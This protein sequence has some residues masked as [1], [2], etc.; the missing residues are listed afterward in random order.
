ML[1]FDPTRQQPPIMP[2]PPAPGG[3]M[4]AAV[5]AGM[6][7]M[8]PPSPEPFGLAVPTDPMAAQDVA[9]PVPD[10]MGTGGDPFLDA[11]MDGFTKRTGFK[12][13]RNWRE[14]PKPTAAQILDFADDQEKRYQKLVDR[15]EDDRKT[16]MLKQSGNFKS[17]DPDEDEEIAGT[18]MTDEINLVANIIAGIDLQLENVVTDPA[19]IEAAQRN[20][21]FLYRA[22]EEAID[23]HALSGNGDLARDE[24]IC[25]TVYGRVV[26]R[27]TP[28]IDDEDWPFRET[29]LDA[30][31]CYPFFQKG[32]LT[33]MVRIYADT[34]GN[35]IDEFDEDGDLAD[36]LLAANPKEGRREK[37]KLDDSVRVVEYYD[38]WYRAISVDDEWVIPVTAH[39]YGVVPF[40]YT[41]VSNGLPSFT[42]MAQTGKVLPDTTPTS[43]EEL[44]ESGL[45]MF[46]FRKKAQWTQDAVNTVLLNALDRDINDP[47]W[48]IVGDEMAQRS[49]GARRI[50]N[51]RGMANYVIKDHETLQPLMTQ[52]N[53][54]TLG[55]LTQA[56]NMDRD[57]GA[58]PRTAYGAS[59]DGQV[60]GNAIEGLNEAGRDKLTPYLRALQQYHARKAQ[61]YLQLWRDFGNLYGYDDMDMPT[62]ALTVPSRRRGPGTDLMSVTITPENIEDTGVKVKCRMTSI[63]LQN[64]GALANA[65][66]MWMQ[67]GTMSRRQ[68]MELRGDP[69]PN[70]TFEEI[71]YENAITSEENQA[72]AMLIETLKRAGMLPDDPDQFQQA[73]AEIYAQFQMAKIQSMLA[74]ATGAGGG[75]G[76]APP[77]GGLMGGMPPGGGGPVGAPPMAPPPAGPLMGPG[78]NQAAMMGLGPGSQGGVVGRP[79][80]M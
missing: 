46:H 28:A 49:N 19:K 41:T 47:A 9:T 70:A 44:A 54:S 51:K 20:E 38:E 57:T 74:Q 77:P 23:R 8:T 4:G 29:L 75:P 7:A 6:N 12:K 2:P 61:L 69:D 42:R 55:P 32:R 1:P 72:V 43:S 36:R 33:K 80:G 11:L 35:I 63:R 71:A 45:A 24:G 14:P 56:L 31:F 65:A 40:V 78:A 37:R 34:V 66:G 60:S 21:N 26:C 22:R 62:G 58:M 73:S 50:V 16:Y 17:F 30:A 53:P 39:E 64:L 27:I 15:F 79:P 25:V 68:A 5:G 10:I 76:G 59:Q 67:A 48:M 13:P 18:G 52:V 3:A